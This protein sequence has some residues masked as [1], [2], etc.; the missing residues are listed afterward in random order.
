MYHTNNVLSD[1]YQIGNSLGNYLDFWDNNYKSSIKKISLFDPE[2]TAKWSSAQRAYFVKLF[3][4][5]RGHFH[6]FLWFMGNIA[7]DKKA[8]QMIV[9]NILEEFGENGFSHEKL[10]YEFAKNLSV[11]LSNEITES[12]YYL[13]FIQEFN[14][15]HLEWLQKHDWAGCL[16]AFSAYERLDNVDYVSLLELA[17]SVG[18]SKLG[19]TFFQVHIHV[20]HF[21]NTL[22]LLSDIWEAEPKK[23]I[24]GFDFIQSHQLNMWEKLS[25]NVFN[26]NG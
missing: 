17:K 7:P 6:S 16:S 25:A 15:G 14:K 19:L 18:A 10:Y 26:Y 4:H 24:D 9:Q 8:K 13:P 11:N 21:D 5:V 3:Y 23:V 20:K 1:Q 22:D 2:K 12:Q